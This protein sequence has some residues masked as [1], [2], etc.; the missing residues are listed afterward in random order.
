[1]LSLRGRHHPSE[2]RLRA[3]PA[4]SPPR[5]RWQAWITMLASDRTANATG[6]NYMID[7][8]LIKTTW[9]AGPGEVWFVGT[10]GSSVALEDAGLDCSAVTTTRSLASASRAWRVLRCSSAEACSR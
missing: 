2:A 10:L 5:S 9:G 7:G 6:A 4:S 1:M 8:G 3:P